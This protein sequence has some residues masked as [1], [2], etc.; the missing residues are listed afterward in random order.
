MRTVAT[1]RYLLTG[2]GLILLVCLIM[3]GCKEKYAAPVTDVNPNYFV[4]EGLINTG[5][6]ST[7]FTL[8][9]TFKL[10]NKAVV[11]PEKAAIVQVESEAGNV[12]VL[13][14]LVKSGSYGRPA[15]GLDQTKRYRLRI[16]TKDNKEYLSDFV[17]SKTSPAIDDIKLEFRNNIMFINANTHDPSGKSRYYR[18][19]YIETWQHDA[20]IQA[21]FKVENHQILLRNF[22]EEDIYHCWTTVPSSS[23]ILGATTGLTEDRL[24][25][26]RLIGIPALSPKLTAEYSIL[27][28]QSVLTK[29]A[30]EFLEAMQKNTERVGGIF[31]AQP[32]QLFGN[33]RSVTNSSEV[34]IG[35]ISAGTLTEKRFT[36]TPA[37]LQDGYWH[38][39]D[40]LI[41]CFE[42]VERL[43]FKDARFGDRVKNE[44]TGPDK[45]YYIPINVY[46]PAGAP[47]LTGYY[48]TSLTECVDCRMQGGTNKKPTFWK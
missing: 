17:E 30:F 33:I 4:V 12:Y 20:Q 48:A 21:L 16:R 5:S 39:K 1:Y 6:D 7:I 11:A 41:Y 25:D 42:G 15:L 44:L 22:P 34:V 14:E 40:S 8:S 37:D 31:D 43:L 27:V 2:S 26:K 28:K 32:S 19:S 10:D 23:I 3:Y 36:V 47:M 13:P 29:E 46:W 24:A 45:P 35:F 18:Y 9:R 38:Q